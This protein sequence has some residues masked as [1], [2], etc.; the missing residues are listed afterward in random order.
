M[1]ESETRL[2]SAGVS[3]ALDEWVRIVRATLRLNTIKDK[4]LYLPV[5]EGQYD[6]TN[7]YLP[8]WAER[9]RGSEKSESCLFRAGLLIWIYIIACLFRISLQYALPVC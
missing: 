5:T 6:L 2:K 7:L 8:I 3:T 1:E 4:N 9:L